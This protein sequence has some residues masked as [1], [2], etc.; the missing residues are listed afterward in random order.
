MRVKLDHCVSGEGGMSL[1]TFAKGN[2]PQWHQFEL[3]ASYALSARTDVYAA[4]IYQ[5]AA[6]DA[7]IAALNL[8]GGVSGANHRS[9]L[10]TVAGIRHRF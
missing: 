6:G 10:L 5:L 2:H 3:G 1:G 4:S 7:Q 9:V 8:Q